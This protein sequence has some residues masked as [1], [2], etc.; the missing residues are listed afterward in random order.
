MMLGWIVAE[1]NEEEALV[2]E[3][4]ELTW[5]RLRPTA[6]PVRSLIAILMDMVTILFAE[7]D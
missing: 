4:A 5:P 6:I 1:T 2:K 3:N 7:K